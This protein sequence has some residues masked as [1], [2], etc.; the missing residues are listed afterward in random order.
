MPPS[1]HVDPRRLLPSVDQV[2]QQ[3]ALRALVGTRGRRAVV[4]ALRSALEELRRAAPH[5]VEARLA[6]L[7]EDVA[8]RVEAAARPSLRR[9]VN[10]TGVVVH[11]NLGRAPLSKEAAARVAEI[12]S[13]YSNLEYDLERGER[14]DRE[15]HAEARLRDLLGVESTVVVNNCAAAVLLAVNTLAEGRE[16]LVSRGELVE[17]GGS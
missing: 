13:S 10:A 16:V 3:P 4:R 2:L 6:R 14:G 5:G 1:T 8:A 17:I 12:A 15:A 7:P 11:T 9:V